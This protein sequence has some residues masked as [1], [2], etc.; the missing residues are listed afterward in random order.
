MPA[1][2]P[3][4]DDSQDVHQTISTMAEA[5]SSTANPPATARDGSRCWR[6]VPRDDARDRG[7]ADQEGVA[8]VDVAVGPVEAGGQRAD[9]HDRRERGAGGLP[10]V[11]AEPEDQQGHDDRPAPD[12]EQTAERPRRGCDQPQAH[13][14]G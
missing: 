14:T 2:R 1:A 6:A 13:E 9:D 12:A 11:V 4:G 3:I 7:D 8:Q 10:V 5:T